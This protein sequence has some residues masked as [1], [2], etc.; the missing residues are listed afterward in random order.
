MPGTKVSQVSQKINTHNTYLYI[1][2]FHFPRISVVQ[3]IDQ[4][5]TAYPEINCRFIGNFMDVFIFMID[6]PKDQLE[7]HAKEWDCYEYGF[8]CIA[9]F[10]QT[11]GKHDTN[12]CEFPSSQLSNTP[13]IMIY[14][15]FDFLNVTN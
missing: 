1:A 3:F 4:Y 6:L 8:M 2:E 7:S 9:V 12:I 14:L 13:D 10:Q 5:N 15:D 11:Y